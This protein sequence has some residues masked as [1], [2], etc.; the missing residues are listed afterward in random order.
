MRGIDFLREPACQTLT[1]TSMGG[2]APA[3]PNLL[4]LRWLGASNYELAHRGTVLLLDAYYQR[5]PP[6]RSLGFTRDD[7]KRADAILIGHP[8]GDHMADAPY[9]A[10]RTGAMFVGSPIA[11]EQ[12]QKMDVS[13][14][15]I[16]AVRNGDVQRFNGFTVEAVLARHSNRTPEFSRGT[17]AAFRALQTAAGLDRTPEALKREAATRQG[18]SADPRLATEGTMAYLFT[19]NNGSYRV[20]YID[21]AGPPTDAARAVMQRIGGRVDIG[22]VGYQGFVFPELS[23]GAS[24]PL[25]RLIKPDVLLPN[26]HDDSGGNRPDLAMYPFFMAVRDEL[27]GTRGISPLY[28]TPLCFDIAAKIAYVGEPWAWRARTPESR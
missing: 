10:K 11:A 20:M 5:V 9:V 28:R 6:A 8:H 12:A 7:I 21:T 22:I 4:V 13:S 17:D 25:V 3:S 27:P 14:E 16:R 2:P 23:N 26:H 24:M 1:P 15:R 19:F 18:G